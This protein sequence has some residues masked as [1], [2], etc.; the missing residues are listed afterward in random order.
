MLDLGRAAAGEMFADPPA[1]TFGRGS[2]DGWQGA[3]IVRVR[4]VSS[5]RL[6]V[7]VAT[8]QRK[9]HVP[10]SLSARRIEI[11][12]GET[13]RLEV[14]ARLVTFVRAEAAT[15]TLTLTPV[16]GVAVRVPW[17]VVL[18]PPADL[19]GPL[20]LSRR[21]FAPS[22]VK[23]AIVVVRA[24]RV[25]RSSHGNEVI[26]VLR[27]DVEVSTAAG[28]R[29]GLL[30]RLRDVLPGRYAFGLTGRGPSGRVLARGRYELRIL[31]WPTGGGPP[32]AR[33][34]RFRIR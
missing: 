18:R 9:P 30:A 21:G 10:V 12:P 3:R 31:A 19:L 22:E 29:I 2:G 17:A 27:L 28:R 26:P 24:G 7:F 13:A 34:V 4:N 23:P 33:S 32:T 15:G 11:E 8:G 1:L 25:V 5:R 14:R 20:A 6:T 16:G